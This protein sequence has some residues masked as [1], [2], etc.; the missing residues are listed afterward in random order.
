MHLSANFCSSSF[1]LCRACFSALLSGD[2]TISVTIY[3][4]NVTKSWATVNGFNAEAKMTLLSSD[5]LKARVAAND[6]GA[7]VAIV[8]TAYRLLYDPALALPLIVA[9]S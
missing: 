8:A 7:A 1:F 9:A 5:R 6:A 4:S 2:I 3:K